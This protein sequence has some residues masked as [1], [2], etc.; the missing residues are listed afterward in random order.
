[1]ASVQRGGGPPKNL[2]VLPADMDGRAVRDAAIYA[3]VRCGGFV[4]F[5]SS[6]KASTG[7]AL[8]AFMA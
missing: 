8:A 1:M 2:K 3:S 5:Y 4:L 6:R 7:L